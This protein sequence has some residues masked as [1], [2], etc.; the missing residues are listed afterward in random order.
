M[1]KSIRIAGIATYTGP[2]EV[3]SD[4]SIFNFIYGSNGSGKM[5]ITRVIAVEQQVKTDTVCFDV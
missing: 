4:L 5:T 2:P 1:I 3:L